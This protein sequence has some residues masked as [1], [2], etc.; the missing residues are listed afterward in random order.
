VTVIAST[1]GGYVAAAYV[2]FVAL[3]LL[4][5]VI[6]AFRTARLERD[7]DELADALERRRS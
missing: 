6:M 4:Y 5:V 2:V 1:G 7:V 3:I